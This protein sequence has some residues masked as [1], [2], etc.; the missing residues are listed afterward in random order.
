MSEYKPMLKGFF[1][2]ITYA[3]SSPLNIKGAK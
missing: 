2:E 3:G 1:N